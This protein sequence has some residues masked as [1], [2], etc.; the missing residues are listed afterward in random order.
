MGNT[1][2]PGAEEP[3]QPTPRRPEG[4]EIGEAPQHQPKKHEQPKLSPSGDAAQ[5]KEQHPRQQGIRD[6][7]EDE[8]LFQPETAEDGR[9]ELV[10]E[11]QS[12]AAEKAEQ[13]L[14]SLAA[15]VDPHQPRSLPRK[16]L[17]RSLSPA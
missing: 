2:R 17:R 11:A 8:P 15:G 9:Q 3:G 7:E 13:G 14:Q 1:G 5:E 12:H 4:R 10:D 6:I 16:P